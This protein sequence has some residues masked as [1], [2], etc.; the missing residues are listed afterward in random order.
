[1]MIRDA[2][3]GAEHKSREEVLYHVGLHVFG[4]VSLVLLRMQEDR[5]VALAEL[6]R[7]K[8]STR[9]ALKALEEQRADLA[10]GKSQ[11]VTFARATEEEA[12]R[13]RLSSTML[14]AELCTKEEALEMAL[15][16]VAADCKAHEERLKGRS[17]HERTGRTGCI[18]WP[19]PGVVPST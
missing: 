11:L 5:R 19:P 9:E 1:M 4:G 18:K 15:E 8:A 7:D 14:E 12:E 13:A 17:G 2:E 16:K 3:R 6:T 10:M